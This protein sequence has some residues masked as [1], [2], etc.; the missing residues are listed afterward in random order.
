MQKLSIMKPVM[1]TWSPIRTSAATREAEEAERRR[2]KALWSAFILVV[3]MVRF[4]W[5]TTSCY[6]YLSL[7][8]LYGCWSFGKE[9]EVLEQDDNVKDT[10]CESLLEPFCRF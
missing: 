5:T 3:V 9:S 1:H 6:Y 2:R 7:C 10:F 4:F 8:C